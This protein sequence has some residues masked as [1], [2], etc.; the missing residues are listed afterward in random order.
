VSDGGR[1]D[2]CTRARV[3]ASQ[4]SGIGRQQRRVL[5]GEED[6]AREQGSGRWAMANW[7]SGTSGI[8]NKRSRAKEKAS[9]N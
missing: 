4:A 2:S 6:E 7:Q 8:E 1:A 9:E 3:W 5:V